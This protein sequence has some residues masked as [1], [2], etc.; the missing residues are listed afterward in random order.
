LASYYL[1]ERREEEYVNVCLYQIKRKEK[2]RKKERKK[3]KKI[4]TD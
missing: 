2:E 4:G 3:D 1:K